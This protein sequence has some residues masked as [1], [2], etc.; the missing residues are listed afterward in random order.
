VVS[1]L[2]NISIGIDSV[3]SSENSKSESPVGVSEEELIRKFVVPL[4]EQWDGR[5]IT[6]DTVF[7]G[8]MR[9]TRLARN[10]RR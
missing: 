7:T 5:A 6:F 9:R 4:I 1:R 2:D 10:S 8:N 3:E